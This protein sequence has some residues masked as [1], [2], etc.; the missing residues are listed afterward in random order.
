LK[1]ELSREELVTIYVVGNMEELID[2]GLMTGD[3]PMTPKGRKIYLEMKENKFRP[4]SEEIQKCVQTIFRKVEGG[5]LE[6][7]HGDEEEE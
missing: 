2:M 4:S 7:L 6:L 5:G 1:E 3:K